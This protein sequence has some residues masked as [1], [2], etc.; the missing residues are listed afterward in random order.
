MPTMV[1]VTRMVMETL[2]TPESSA[3]VGEE[4]KKLPEASVR[5][6][7]LN[8]LVLIYL[9]LVAIYVPVLNHYAYNYIG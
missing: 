4:I 6:M 1:Q 8:V 7:R 2:S 5:A 9:D 3:E